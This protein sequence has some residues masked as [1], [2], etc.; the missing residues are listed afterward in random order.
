MILTTKID[1]LNET[2]VEELH[3]FMTTLTDPIYQVEIN[4]L[5]L[6]LNY[7]N[8]LT[9]VSNNLIEHVSMLYNTETE[10]ITLCVHQTAC[11]KI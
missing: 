5:F 4:N 2:A 3:E 8:L 6:K 1:Y 10:T 7:G 9:L 11:Q